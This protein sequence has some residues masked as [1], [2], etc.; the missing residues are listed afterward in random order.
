MPNRS[1]KRKPLNR[2]LY[3]QADCFRLVDEPASP[4][5]EAEPYRSDFRRDYARLIHSPAFRRLQ[6]KTQ[7]FPGIESDFFRNRLT[8]SLEVAQI[9]KSIGLRLNSTLK[10]NAHQPL[11]L[12]LIELAALA[13]DLGHPPF[14]HNGEKALDDCMKKYGGFE[15]NAQTL[16][17]LSVLE[18]KRIKENRDND[19]IGASGTDYRVGLNLTV[20]AL[21]AVLKYDKVIPVRREVQSPLV[22]GYY[23]SERKLVDSIKKN[24]LGD[25]YRK[26]DGKFKT[27]ECQIMDVADD[28]AYSTYDLEDAFK[29]G[30]LSP[31]KLVSASDELMESVCRKVYE[32]TRL[33]AKKKFDNLSPSQK[34]KQKIEMMSDLV[35]LLEFSGVFSTSDVKEVLAYLSSDSPF[36]FAMSFI[37]GK[38]FQQSD[39]VCADGYIR[40]DF[41]SKLVGKFIRGVSIEVDEKCPPL[42]K[43][44]V[45][46]DVLREIEILKHFAYESLIMSSRLKVAEYRGSEV[47]SAIFH[48]LSNSESS[49]LPEDVRKLYTR[50]KNKAG[51]MRVISDFVAGMTD[52]YA[53]EFYGRL[54]SES[55]ES[56]F[57]P[58]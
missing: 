28:I 42:S 55:P 9:A 43:I 35:K 53:L 48:A 45:D 36:S 46:K 37:V 56:I 27:V 14:G 16:R 1:A 47:V 31:L 12:D 54:K 11:N 40:T 29:A 44:K 10:S 30:F 18:K 32:N 50:A 38:S 58:L 3:S 21:G 7:L 6:G 20:R 22:K 49:L 5:H 19:P 33:N 57:K 24:V 17:I 8:H 34:E 4:Q 26:F 52:R 51:K 41:T 23:E 25:E 2:P 13:H 39:N 15:G